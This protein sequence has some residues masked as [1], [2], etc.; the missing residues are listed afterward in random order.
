MLSETPSMVC[1]T[2]KYNMVKSRY[3]RPILNAVDVELHG[4][5]KAVQEVTPKH[6][7]V[8]GGVYGM[9]PPCMYKTPESCWCL[10]WWKMCAVHA[11]ITQKHTWWD[12]EGVALPQLYSLAVVTLVPQENVSLFPW[13]N[14]VFIHVQILW[15]GRNQPEHL[16][17]Q[18]WV[19][20]AGRFTF[21]MILQGN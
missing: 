4:D 2:N 8:L 19:F 15:R 9:D 11:S 6:Q 3:P 5:V 13:Q 10:S 17:G 12:N 20:H 14:P 1:H 16:Q 7:S 18:W 21:Q